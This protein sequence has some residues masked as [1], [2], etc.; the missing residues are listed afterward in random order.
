[1]I[2][3]S[4]RVVVVGPSAPPVTGERICVSNLISALSEIGHEC[5][6]IENNDL[7]KRFEGSI[8]WYF[9]GSTRLG[10]CRDITRI[11]LSLRGG[12]KVYVNIHN[13]SWRYFV[14][15]PFFLRRLLK[16]TKFV[17]LS[18]VVAKS[19]SQKGYNAE[20]F[21]N[22]VKKSSIA[23]K[24]SNKRLIWLGMVSSEKGFDRAYEVFLDLLKRDSDWSFD[25]YGNYTDKFQLN[26]K[27]ANFM[28]F[29][30]NNE[31]SRVFLDGGLLILPSRYKNENQ[32]L[33]IL[34]AF[35]HGVPVVVSDMGGLP[36]MVQHRDDH[37]GI[38]ISNGCTKKYADAAMTIADN[39][40]SFAEA[41]KRIYNKKYSYEV[42][43]KRLKTFLVK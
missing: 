6:H 4:R 41:A 10:F 33:S 24:Q 20:R 29:I 16:T 32:P 15:L 2:K 17:V 31:V 35:A 27:L 1:M 40:E 12:R 14:G 7:W 39:Y 26:A 28:G 42:Y 5:E 18:D 30:A 22:Y 9:S 11:L 34:E 13:S 8:V 43:L 25:V 3:M 36:E 37:A 21:D 19:L 23:T 38:S